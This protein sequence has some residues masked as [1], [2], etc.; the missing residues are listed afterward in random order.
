[1]RT[2]FVTMFAVTAAQAIVKRNKQLNKRTKLSTAQLL[3][4]LEFSLNTAHTCSSDISTGSLVEP[5][6]VQL[7]VTA[8]SLTSGM[9]KAMA[10]EG[11]H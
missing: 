6:W 2:L 4:L 3:C 8:T 11:I 1:M 10:A 9:I 5:E 7:S